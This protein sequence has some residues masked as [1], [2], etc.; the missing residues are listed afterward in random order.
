MGEIIRKIGRIVLSGSI[1]LAIL[2][3]FCL[4]FSYSKLHIEQP[5]GASD[6]THEPYSYVSKT[7]E[8]FAWNIMDSNGYNNS[9]VFDVTDVLLMG[10]S[11]ME[12]LQL[13]QR[14]SMTYLLNS[15]YLPEYHSY[16]IGKSMHEIYTCVQ[17]LHS[18][19]ERLEPQKY[20]VIDISS[21]RLDLDDMELVLENKYPRAWSVSNPIKKWIL[22]YVPITGN[23]SSK[24]KEWIAKDSNLVGENVDM[25]DEDM[26]KYE[27]LLDEFL[28]YAEN[29]MGGG[30]RL[31]ILYHPTDYEVDEN[32]EFHFD[33]DPKYDRLFEETCSN[34]DIV[35]VNMQDEFARM[36]A[37][38][39]VL[40]NGFV[41]TVWGAGHLNKYGHDACAKAL[42]ETIRSLDAEE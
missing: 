17:N 1:A 15:E 13:P 40:P 22:N 26:D 33:S 34:H 20:V 11:H 25:C 37:E 18:A 29:A 39:H 24:L 14:E 19:Y 5:S 36:Y 42:A 27:S 16:N 31:I 9:M 12:A 6:Y 38:D 32:G 28:E 35:F 8:G 30:T 10:G 23:V 4:I 21:T 3:V 7:D 41:N 2:S